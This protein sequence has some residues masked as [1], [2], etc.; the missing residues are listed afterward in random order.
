MGPAFDGIGGRVDA[1]YIRNSILEPAAGAA[2][3]FEA[4]IGV[5]PAIFG[6][7]LTAAQLEAVVQFL[8]SQQ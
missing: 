5:M 2:E 6:T 1:D 4:F 3:G 7:Q 8:A